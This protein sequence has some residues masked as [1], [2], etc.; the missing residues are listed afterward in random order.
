MLQ[1]ANYIDGRFSR[2]ISSKYLDNIDPSIGEVYSQIPDSDEKDV[3]NA[4]AAAKAAFDGWAGM[5]VEKRSAILLKIAD[6]IDRDFEKLAMAESVDNGKPVSLAKSLDIPR[7]AA[8]I[9]FYATG[10]IHFA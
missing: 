8:N 7:A 10:A 2:P 6:L 3:T 4:V 5:H 9:R 1:I